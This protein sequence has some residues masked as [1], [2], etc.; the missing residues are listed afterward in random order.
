MSE[1]RKMILLRLMKEGIGMQNSNFVRHH[2]WSHV[3]IKKIFN[4]LLP[5]LTYI[6][7]GNPITLVGQ[8]PAPD[9]RDVDVGRISFIHDSVLVKRGDDDQWYAT[10]LNT[11]VQT[12][13][14]L[15]VNDTG[16]TELEFDGNFYRLN[17]YSGFDILDVSA[18]RAQFSLYSGTLTV[19]LRYALAQ[20]V[21]IDLP[22]ASVTVSKSGLYRFDAYD[23]AG[24]KMTVWQG[25]AQVNNG[26]SIPVY[27]GQQIVVRDNNYDMTTAD[28]PDSWD[29]WNTERN[30]QLEKA[31]QSHRNIA[32]NRTMAGVEDLEYNG[33]WS[34]LPEYGWG[35]TPTAVPA[36]WAPY[37]EGRWIWRD[38]YGW[39]WLSRERWGWAPYHYGRWVYIGPRWY[40]VPGSYRRYSPALVGFVSSNGGLYI[41]WVPLAPRDEFIPWWGAPRPHPATTIVYYN[42]SYGSS[43]TITTTVGFAS[44]VVRH[45]EIVAREG[46]RL[47]DS[48]PI[49]VINVIP[50]RRSLAPGRGLVVIVNQSVTRCFDR[51]VVVVHRDVPVV[52]PFSEKIVEIRHGNGIPVSDFRQDSKGAQVFRDPSVG[53]RRNPSAVE[54]G[55][56]RPPALVRQPGLGRSIGNRH[57]GGIPEPGSP[58]RPPDKVIKTETQPR[59]VQPHPVVQP[60]ERREQV[61]QERKPPPQ[62]K[63]SSEQMRQR[64]P[65]KGQRQ[66]STPSGEKIKNVPK[67]ERRQIQREVKK[68]NNPPRGEEKKDK[69]GRQ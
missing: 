68:P 50:T 6:I 42:Q 20:P 38:P 33:A 65:D 2:I 8:E 24:M 1:V 27:A 15:Y 61:L 31:E 56:N 64:R 21:E 63:Q 57:V 66:G 67:Q 59:R 62:P 29:K 58:M 13:D 11:P 9:N 25:E 5:V 49:T 53:D 45:R 52:R 51:R 48:R 43:I 35:W 54:S 36:G 23:S 39:T 28:P 17:S 41:G 3:F 7:L 69:P 47:Q 46:F 40:W 37:R 22:E 60:S 55:H 10:V 4:Y 44:G 19:Y 14:R 18:S 32:E 30:Q 26:S 16:R 34:D 12:G